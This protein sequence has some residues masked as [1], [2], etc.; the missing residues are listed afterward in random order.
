MRTVE[1]IYEAL[2]AA[3]GTADLEDQSLAGYTGKTPP[4]FE[5]YVDRA[6]EFRFRLR[7]SGGEILISSEGY[8]S[9]SNCL[10]GIR[11]VCRHAPLADLL[12]E[13]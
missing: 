7:L 13:E 1:A 11:S 5:L 2:R 10:R 9:K 6:G 4:K 8:L 12:W 3:C